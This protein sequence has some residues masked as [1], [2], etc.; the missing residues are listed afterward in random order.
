MEIQQINVADPNVA[1]IIT[2]FGYSLFGKA[3]KW[4]NLGREGRVHTTVSDWN[5]LKEQFK[6]QFNPV[7]N[8]REE[9]MV[10][11]RNI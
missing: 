7:G 8:T 3:K 1:K 5:A 9:E 6:K 10:S 11:W 2:R 4:F